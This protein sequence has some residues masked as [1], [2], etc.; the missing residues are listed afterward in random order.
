MTFVRDQL[1]AFKASL[2]FVLVAENKSAENGL[3]HPEG[4]ASLGI[5]LHAS[6]SLVVALMVSLLFATKCDI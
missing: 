1:I 3:P 2:F 6:R 4:P 5:I